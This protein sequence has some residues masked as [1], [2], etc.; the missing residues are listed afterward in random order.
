M[1]VRSKRFSIPKFKAE[2][3]LS[4]DLLNQVVERFLHLSS[5][6][7]E[8]GEMNE[9]EEALLQ[10]IIAHVHQIVSIYEIIT[11]YGEKISSALPSHLVELK[12]KRGELEAFQMIMTKNRKLKK[13]IVIKKGNAKPVSHFSAITNLETSLLEKER[14]LQEL[15]LKMSQL[16]NAIANLQVQRKTEE[17]E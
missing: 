2:A 6:F 5:V 12:K 9:A 16:T 15:Q 11:T 10:K 4:I 14:K 17:K 1:N 3:L 8:N 7:L 13:E